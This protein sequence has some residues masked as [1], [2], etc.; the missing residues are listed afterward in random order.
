MKKLI[1]SIAFIIIVNNLYSQAVSGN[2]IIAEGLARIKVKPDIANFTIQ[3]SKRNNVEKV[4]ITALNFETLK[5]EK[6]LRKIGLS[7]KNIKITDYRVSK[8]DYNQQNEVTATK[9]QKLEYNH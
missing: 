7:E 5:V 1:L 8:N 9:L 4:A 6:I 3:V 2:Q